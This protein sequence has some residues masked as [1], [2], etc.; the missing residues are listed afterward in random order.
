M[1]CDKT[2]VFADLATNTESLT[3]EYRTQ[4][5]ADSHAWPG[6]SLAGRAGLEVPSSSSGQLRRDLSNHFRE[7]ERG[8]G[9]VPIP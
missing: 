3:A 2:T 5:V 7:F 6:Q 1:T 4:G 8:G 9:S